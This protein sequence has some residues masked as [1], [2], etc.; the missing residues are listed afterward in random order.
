VA[1]IIPVN[2][3]PYRRSL[4]SQFSI[5]FDTY[6]EILHRVDRRVAKAMHH[7]TPEWR[8]KN[9]CPPCHY[10]V[11]DEPAM[12]F[13]VQKEMD[14][15]NSLKRMDE[16]VRHGAQ[17]KDKRKAR[18]DYWQTRDEVDVYKDEVKARAKA[19]VLILDLF[20]NLIN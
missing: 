6:L 17:S 19:K 20:L 4:T 5:A 18:T 7:D 13:A 10:K 14:G 1:D 9:S 16:V 12:T 2:Q 15:N 11:E 8:M 3:V